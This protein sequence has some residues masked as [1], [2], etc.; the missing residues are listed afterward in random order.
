MKTKIVKVDEVKIESLIKKNFS[1]EFM[2]KIYDIYSDD[3][4]SIVEKTILFDKLFT[5]E[6]G[7]RKDY[8]RIGEGTNRF[9]CLLD[10]HI[11]KV[12]YNYLAYIDNMNELAQAKYKKKYLA[13]A[14]ETNGIILV[15]EYVTVMDKEDFLENQSPI[16]KILNL[17]EKDTSLAG[18]KE[19]RYI[20]GDMGMS[21]KNYGNWGRRMN[22]DIVVLDYGY[23]YQL[24]EAEWKEVS[25]C[26]ICGSSLKYTSD[27]S[28][29]ICVQNA[30]HEVQYTTLRNVHGY[31]NII[32]N[33]KENLNDDKYVIRGN[34][35]R[36]ILPGR[37]QPSTFGTGELNYCVRYG[38]RWDL[39]VITT[40]RG[41]RCYLNF[42]LQT[43]L[44]KGVEDPTLTTAQIGFN[45]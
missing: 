8:R 28:Q 11:I 39:S 13:Q 41:F 44:Q 19:R 40:G 25:K 3:C 6:F 43:T 33:I 29:L 30:K 34:R 5:E 45:M 17:L 9:V 12:A 24:S 42:A 22:G 21:E 26:P 27:F 10:N 1:E 18:N 32:E 35:Q 37:V 7:H 15:S 36:P 23:L 14:Y 16:F 2:R 4:M 20:L 31:A 38:N